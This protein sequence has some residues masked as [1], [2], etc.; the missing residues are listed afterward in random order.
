MAKFVRIDKPMNSKARKT[1]FRTMKDDTPRN[2]MTNPKNKMKSRGGKPKTT[3]G[4]L[5]DDLRMHA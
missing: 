4:T 5:R 2:F 3:A 1:V